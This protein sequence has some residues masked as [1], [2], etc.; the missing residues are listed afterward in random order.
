MLNDLL[1]IEY[2]Q[3]EGMSVMRMIINNYYINQPFWFWNLNI[4]GN[5]DNTVAADALAPWVTKP[6]A[7]IVMTMQDRE[8]LFAKRN[9]LNNLGYLIVW[10]RQKTNTVLLSCT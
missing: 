2:F 4:L 8:S 3:L 5:K 7:A 1:A 10:K 6:S 9:H